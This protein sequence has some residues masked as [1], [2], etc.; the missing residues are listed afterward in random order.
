[1]KNLHYDELH[2]VVE[3]NYSY[4]HNVH[5]RRLYAGN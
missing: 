5:K 3:A 2:Y 1:M 4:Q